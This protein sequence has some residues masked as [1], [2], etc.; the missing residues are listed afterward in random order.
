MIQR[1]YARRRACSASA[2]QQPVQVRRRAAQPFPHARTAVASRPPK[3]LHHVVDRAL[4]ERSHRVLVV[5]GHEDHVAA[6]AGRRATSRPVMPGIWMSRNSTSGAW[7]SNARMA[8]L[9]SSATATNSS[10]GHSA[11]ATPS[12]RRAGAVRLQ[13]GS[14]VGRFMRSSR[15]AHVPPPSLHGGVRALPAS[16]YSTWETLAD[17]AA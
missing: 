6:A 10:S 2:L 8:C 3:R 4:L 9:P 1:R 7:L 5:G 12:A 16:P 13:R 11:R 14:R 15:V 17:R